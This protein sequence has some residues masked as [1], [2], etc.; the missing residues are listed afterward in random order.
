MSRMIWLLSVPV[1]S[2]SLSCNSE[3]AQVPNIEAETQFLDTTLV[4]T[5]DTD[6]RYNT[7]YS[8]LYRDSRTGREFIFSGD[9]V[10]H[11]K[12]RVFDE[13][14]APLR[15][16]SLDSAFNVLDRVHC[17]TLLA[18]DTVAI[19]DER[20]EKLVILDASGRV[21]RERVLVDE[22][23]DENDD[24]YELY[25][26]NTGL[27]LLGGKLYIGP[28]LLGA[29]RGKSFYQRSDT[30]YIDARRYYALATGKCQVAQLDPGAITMGVRF[31]A[32]GLL[33]HLT[34]TPRETI[35]MTYTAAVNGK[36]FLFSAYSQF[37]HELD[38]AALEVRRRIPIR[39]V[40]GDAGITP[41]PI[42]KG[43]FD[44]DGSALR[45]S[46]KAYVLSFT[47]DVPSRS[48]LAGVCHEVPE[49]TPDEGR[50]W[51]RNWS[52]VVLDSTFHPRGECVFSGMKYSGSVLLGLR[53]GTWLLEKNLDPQSH[54]QPKIFRRV[55]V[56]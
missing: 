20:G 27:T 42:T 19:L 50:S 11:L 16:I 13:H 34:D 28:A 52:M 4:L 46:T 39:Y 55:V 6:W 48:Y 7:N 5:L 54:R 25:P 8:G 49:N 36:V 9:P 26:T 12:V 37:V 10:T 2:M 1:M 45:L 41:P 29:C 18:E 40:N 38:T 21:V 3:S 56:R 43:D 22:R 15:D 51:R 30:G 23:C 47:Y 35:G 14:G 32:S 31:G 17:L 53:T 33:E 24:L 44:R